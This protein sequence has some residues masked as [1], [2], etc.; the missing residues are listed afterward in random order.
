MA[1]E[2][3]LIVEDHTMIAEY[4]ASVLAGAG[5]RPIQVHTLA[6]ARE[7]LA[8]QRFDLLLCDRFLPD[9]EGQEL[10]AMLGTAVHAKV[11]AIALSAD[12]DA[13]VQQE[14][15]AGGFTGTLAKPCR[16][17]QLLECVRQVLEGRPGSA[18]SPAPA[19]RA[20]DPPV[21]DDAAALAVCAGNAGIMASMRRLLAADLPALRQRL[22]AAAGAGDAHALAQE[23]HRLSAAAAWCGAAEVKALCGRAGP[24]PFHILADLD[25]ALERLRTALDG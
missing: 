3:I 17:A 6:R 25:A 2:S 22:S 11:P 16:P 10:L 21:L 1:G 20:G 18:V 7:V 15:M 13:G 9:G 5:Y 23:L 14:L 12:M 24:D 19:A 4:V 8:R